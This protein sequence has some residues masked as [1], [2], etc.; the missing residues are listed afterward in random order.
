MRAPPRVY[1]AGPDVFLP[2]ATAR[3]DA[4]KAICRTHGLRGV[5]PLDAPSPPLPDG[6][7][8]VPDWHRI[9]RVNEA[10]IRGA[11]ALIANLTPFR[12][13]SADVGTV[14]EVG[15]MRA[16]GRPVFAWSASGETLR[17]RSGGGP[18]D[19]DGL[20]V[21]DF[22]LVENLMIPAAITDSGGRLHAAPLADAW[23]DL[24]LFEA[25]VRDAARLLLA[26]GRPV[27]A[28]GRIGGAP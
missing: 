21:E 15:F 9:A 14:F 22:G 5:F 13:P 16:L 2:D 28:A 10:H 25:C 3:A 26:P 24:S 23:S 20:A 12:G 4:L 19:A 18:R 6:A 8:D 1:L 7:A 11:D 17:A 27:I